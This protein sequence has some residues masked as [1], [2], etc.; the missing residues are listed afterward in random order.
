MSR[1]IVELF[2]DEVLKNIYNEIKTSYNNEVLFFSWLNEE[3]K[4]NR[5]EVIARGN[6]ECVSFPIQ[7]SYLPD[8]VIHNH[9]NGVLRPSEADMSIASFIAQ[10]GVGFIIVNNELTDMYVA[11]EPVQKKVYHPISN[12][13]CIS[14][15]SSGSGIEK[16]I[17]SFEERE[18]QKIM[19]RE[20]CRS[21]NEDKMALIEAGTGIG[22]T[23]AY[24]IPA[25]EWAIVNHERVVISTNTINLQEQLLKKDIPTV[26]KIMRKDFEYSLMKGRGNYICVNRVMEISQDLF[27]FI[28]DEEREQFDE[29]LAWIRKTD[30]GS[31]SDLP[32]T[33]SPT[34][35]EKVNSKTE[36][37]M[38]AR[39][40]YFSEC[41]F[42]RIKR[43][44]LRSHI[45]ITNHHYFL[46][47][48]SLSDS[49]ASVLPSYTRVVFDEA[50]RLEDSATS[51]FT[52]SLNEYVVKVLLNQ[53]H[54]YGKGK[55]DKGYISYLKKKGLLKDSTQYE[56]VIKIIDEV[57]MCSESLFAELGN[58]I[59][60]YVQNE[61]NYRVEQKNPYQVIEIDEKIR[62]NH[63]WI[64]NVLSKIGDFYRSVSSLENFLLEIRRFLN[65]KK[66]ELETKQIDGYITRLIDLLQTIDIFLKDE[67]TDYVKW[68]ENRKRPTISISLIDVGAQLGEMIYDKAKSLIMTSATLTV[69]GEFNFI[70]N[71]LGIKTL[72]VDAKI[73]SPFDYN[74]QMA[75]M[76]PNDIVEPQH[77]F[78][79]NNIISAIEGIIRKTGGSTLILFTSYATLNRVYSDI[80]ERL[81]SE[82]IVFL[83]QG[84]IPRQVLLDYFKHQKNA[85][86]FGTESFWEGVDVPGENLQCVVITKLPFKVPTDPVIRSRLKRIEQDGKNSFINYLLPLAV[87]KTK[88][89][90]GR[91]IRKRTDRGIIV[92]LD[93]RIITRNY[94]DIFIKSLP[95]A[96]LYISGL[97]DILSI[98]K[99]YIGGEGVGLSS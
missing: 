83:K 31:L 37:C 43:Y 57:K 50:H 38:G 73:D 98:V 14:Y 35:W 92:V 97:K 77:P 16:I 27:S 90:V 76:I 74:R 3:G 24:L 93:R 87:I 60:V 68:V 6:E 48:S 63:Q 30:D 70:K 64:S 62:N 21:F 7:R 33:P 23:F 54:K 94:G 80:S 41:F 96:S 99:R 8:V 79:I 39:C 81:S 66:R 67:E 75:V 12:E 49:G 11:V 36:T 13:E 55:S 69:K 59:E 44:A 91:L 47:D 34:L 72:T 88:Q 42:N 58:F 22:K 84:D 1:K 40:K 29:I 18:G 15:L 25:I 51:F 10:H 28:D 20:V 53:L 78:Y 2:T 95:E 4:I 46:A 86:L 19:V 65:S 5:V 17:E 52:K 89:G 71:R 82:G 85:V 26:K 61:S 32:F 45:V 9:P 56:N